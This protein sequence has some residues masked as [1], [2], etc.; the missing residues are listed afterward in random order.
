LCIISKSFN[1]TYN[2]DIDFISKDCAVTIFV[3][4]SLLA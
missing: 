3:F 1:H 4:L 2:G